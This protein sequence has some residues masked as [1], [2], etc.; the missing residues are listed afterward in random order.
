M[1]HN[2]IPGIYNYCDRWCEHCSFTSR[3]RS[4]ERT[5]ELTQ[6][7]TNIGNDAFWENMSAG[8]EQAVTL[9]REAAKEQGI[10]LDA[11]MEEMDHSAYEQKQAGIKDS[12]KNHPL[13][14][15]GDQYMKTTQPF[16]SEKD[17]LKETT[18]QLL[19]Q[20]GLNLLTEK[21][22]IQSV[23][24]IGDCFDVITWYLFFI[25]SKLHRA[26]S[27]KLEDEDDETEYDF[28]KDYNG[29]AKIAH[30]AI[31]RSMG[32]W[33]KLYTLVPS[34]EDTALNALSLLSK[35][36]NLVI[37]TF[38]QAMAFKRPGFDD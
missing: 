35:M 12:I 26:L 23:K 18:D 7:Q 20:V 1:E 27:G 8:F 13:T 4:Y 19:Q 36:K 15:L 11:A 33:M 38:P 3:C 10:D 30:I 25:N 31:E 9:I 28:P 32:A 37:E 21:E 17:L 34:F 16:I 6:E 24:D 29:S 14:T 22:V 2:F 5:S